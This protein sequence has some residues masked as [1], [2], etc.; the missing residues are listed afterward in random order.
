MKVD[1]A[2]DLIQSL[3][4]VEERLRCCSEV[5]S[6]AISWLSSRHSWQEWGTGDIL[7]TDAACRLLKYSLQQEQGE[8]YLLKY[9][10][11]KE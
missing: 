8:C 10:Q 6:H 2:M 3:D 7:L 9:C 1:E 4:G 11:Q 5:V